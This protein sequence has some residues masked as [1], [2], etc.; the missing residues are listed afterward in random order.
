MLSRI[1]SKRGE[2]NRR[3]CLPDKMKEFFSGLG[4]R[5]LSQRII[6]LLQNP[7]LSAHTTTGGIAPEGKD[8]L[9]NAKIRIEE[10]PFF[11]TGVNDSSKRRA[12]SKTGEWG[13]NLSR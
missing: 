3:Q 9:D 13:L 1:I 6:R 2:N 5:G 7:I 4:L 11:V 12:K 10:R 8:S